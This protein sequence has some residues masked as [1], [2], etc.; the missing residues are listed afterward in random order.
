MPRQAI[1][2][3]VCLFVS[4]LTVK[5]IATNLITASKRPK[6]PFKTTV[7]T[8]TFTVQNRTVAI[9][10]SISVRSQ[11]VQDFNVPRTIKICFVLIFIQV[12]MV[13]FHPLFWYSKPITME[14]QGYSLTEMTIQKIMKVSLLFLSLIQYFRILLFGYG[15]LVQ[16]LWI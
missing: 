2:S 5:M 9:K 10:S 1:S 6:E 14:E 3:Q 4:N 12:Q 16:W 13:N 11:T 8:I 7:E 15:M